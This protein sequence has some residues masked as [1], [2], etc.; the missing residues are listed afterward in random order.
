M[1]LENKA[2]LKL[3][4]FAKKNP[5]LVQRAADGFEVFSIWLSS[6]LFGGIDGIYQMAELPYILEWFI[7]A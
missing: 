3:T 5:L 1:R 4:P 6:F 7:G 2:V